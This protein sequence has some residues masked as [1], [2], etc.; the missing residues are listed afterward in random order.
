V[1][2]AQTEVFDADKVGSVIVLRHWRRGDRFQPSGL[3]R[4]AKL[5]NL[6]VNRRIPRDGRHQLVIAT[7]AKGTIFWVEGLRISEGFKLDKT[8]KH[9]LKWVWHRMETS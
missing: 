4:P 7:T 8:S 6:F 2:E 1:G 3:G 9:G 5:Q